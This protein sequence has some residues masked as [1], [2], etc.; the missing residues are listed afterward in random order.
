MRLSNCFN[1]TTSGL[2][3]KV[4][5]DCCCPVL[6]TVT[7]E[8]GEDCFRILSVVIQPD[9]GEDPN[10]GV[11]A[12]NGVAYNQ[13]SFPFSFANPFTFNAS[14]CAKSSI[15]VNNYTLSIAYED[16]NGAQQIQS[17]QFQ[18]ET[19]AFNTSWNPVQIGA[20]AHPYDFGQLLLGNSA[21]VSFTFTNE[22]MCELELSEVVSGSHPNEITSDIPSSPFLVASGQTYTITFEYI[23]TTLGP[24]Q[25]TINYI[26]SKCGN[27]SAGGIRFSGEGIDPQ[28]PTDPECMDCEDVTFYTESITSQLL[29]SQNVGCT[30]TP[31][32][33]M[34]L[35]AFG[36]KKVFEFEFSYPNQLQN[37]VQF[38]FLP[39]L[40]TDFLDFNQYFTN[41]VINQA[42]TVAYFI[43]YFVG[44]GTVPM[45]LIGAGAATNSQRN[46]ICEFIEGGTN[47]EFKI[48]LTFFFGMDLDTI[49][50]NSV[51]NNN[52]RLL[53]SN[54]Y[55][56]TQ[57]TNT[58]PNVYLNDKEAAFLL[59]VNDPNYQIN[60]PQTNALRDYFCDKQLTFRQTASFL[61]R[62][63][64]DGPS[65]F[66]FPTFTLQRN[67]VNV[68]DF[69]TMSKTNL[70]FDVNVPV[71]YDIDDTI[72]HVIEVDSSNNLIGFLDSYNSSRSEIPTNA[73]QSV[74]DNLLETP[75][76]APAF[77]NG[78]TWRTTA[79]IG[80]GVSVGQIYR[81]IAIVYDNHEENVPIVRSF[82]SPEITVTDIPN[83]SDLCCPPDFRG[84]FIDY[85][86]PYV[87][88][89]FTSTVKERYCHITSITGGDMIDCLIAIG[90]PAEK[91]NEWINYVTG[92]D[93]QILREVVDYPN[94]GE[95]TAFIFDSFTST[96]NTAYPGNWNSPNKSFD[97]Y[98][99]A[100]SNNPAINVQ[101]CGR[102]RYEDDV[103]PTSA[104]VSLAATP[105]ERTSYPALTPVYVAAN[106]ITYDWA[107][108]DIIHEYKLTL[109]LS[110]LTGSPLTLQFVWRPKMVPFDFEGTDGIFRGLN[111]IDFFDPDG[112][113]I[114]G[115]I[116]VN[117]FPY[118]LVQTN[119][120]DPQDLSLIATIDP[121]PTGVNVLEEEES[122]SSPLFILNQLTTPKLFDVD[123]VFVNNQAFFK[124]DLTQLPAGNYQICS[125]ALPYKKKEGDAEGPK[126]EGK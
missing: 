91:S 1:L 61:N 74:L 10:T 123:I 70:I 19:I 23:A 36:E 48:R 81:V 22:Q 45:V 54:I 53:K 96:R 93:M 63:L 2:T 67:N 122:Y 71:G 114:S 106:N 24:I 41:G 49:L 73:A 28:P 37:G 16:C 25:T 109:D 26:T 121:V 105:Y 78:N 116:C 120:I 110:P 115:P 90:L 103:V 65:E 60:D 92:L 40:W 35:N 97:V 117:A 107:G 82:I 126:K 89:C 42:P 38:Y 5:I 66:T 46:L 80:T 55:E 47:T 75:S 14:L 124:V 18:I 79:T 27:Q 44:I 102:V 112:V 98:D 17:F 69:S 84:T 76:T 20:G 119:K 50:S 52:D 101:F 11:T 83:P 125:I 87:T 94:P 4:Y 99:T 72:F 43:Q 3:N 118:V 95:T 15:G 30:L 111:K 12:I 64:Y 31:G 100:P 113:V 33:V 68:A 6:C 57:L 85:N 108:H 77:F 34:N 29:P 7:P 88:D 21:S 39:E 32:T 104:G 13:V 86:N 58:I 62:G 51:L 56:A 59:Y 8:K 9:S